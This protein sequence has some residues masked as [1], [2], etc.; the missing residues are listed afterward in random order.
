MREYYVWSIILL[1]LHLKDLQSFLLRASHVGTVASV[2]SHV[3]TVACVPCPIRLFT[4]SSQPGY[5]VILV[6][7]PSHPSQSTCSPQLVY[8][9]LPFSRSC[10]SSPST[11]S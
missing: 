3:G 6:R 5:L 10:P 9:V 2:P 8:L 1:D 11:L 4:L 7:V